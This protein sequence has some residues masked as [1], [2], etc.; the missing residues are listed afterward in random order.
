MGVDAKLIVEKNRNGQTGIVNLKF[1]P[2]RMLFGVEGH[3]TAD[4]RPADLD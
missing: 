1:Y 2:R 4:D 3:Y